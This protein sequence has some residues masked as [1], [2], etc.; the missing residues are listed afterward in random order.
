[1]VPVE[2]AKLAVL[3]L[4]EG[5]RGMIRESKTA[6]ATIG[7]Q[8][9]QAE[10]SHA[11]FLEVPLFAHNEKSQRRVQVFWSLLADSVVLLNSWCSRPEHVLRVQGRRFVE[12][13]VMP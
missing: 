3:D 11:F 7:M 9:Q 2:E 5:F 8:P 10:P 1:M 13:N 4:P 12:T 6:N